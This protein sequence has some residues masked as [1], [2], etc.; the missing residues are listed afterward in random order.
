MTLG[1]HSGLFCLKQPS[2][3]VNFFTVNIKLIVLGGAPAKRLFY[4]APNSA[5]VMVTVR[6]LLYSHEDG[7]DNVKCITSYLLL[8]FDILMSDGN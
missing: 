6:C 5:F 2:L 8:I 4:N 1:R 3:V 7:Q